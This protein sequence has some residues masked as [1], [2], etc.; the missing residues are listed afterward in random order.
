MLATSTNRVESKKIWSCLPGATA[1]IES[2]GDISAR[3]TL[4]P[5]LLELVNLRC[6][7]LNGCAYCV[8][9]HTDN[10]I[11][12]GEAAHR[13]T[14]LPVWPEAGCYTE[15]EMAAFAWAE[16]VTRLSETHAPDDVWQIASAVFNDEELAALTLAVAT[17]N[18]WNR[19]SV[20]FRFPP[21]LPSNQIG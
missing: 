18:V 19:M 8:Q 13:I 20:S 14:L 6:S 10:L 17:I 5:N 3:S 2:L 11:T 16:A 15:R 4:E 7:Q 21:D 1:A 12:A 9:Y